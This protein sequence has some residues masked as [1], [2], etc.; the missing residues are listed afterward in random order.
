MPVLHN[1]KSPS[2][3][4]VCGVHIKLRLHHPKGSW[5]LCWYLA[6]QVEVVLLSKSLLDHLAVTH[7]IRLEW[8]M[9]IGLEMLFL[10]QTC[11]TE[12]NNTRLQGMYQQAD[13]E[14]DTNSALELVELPAPT[15]TC[16]LLLGGYLKGN[17]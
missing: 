3:L 4:L 10:P 9:D 15:C 8:L 2:K 11:W 1:S 6:N 7:E 14:I 5:K 16:A 17:V 13:T 12:A